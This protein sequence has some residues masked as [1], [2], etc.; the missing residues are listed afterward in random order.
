M[1][2][3]LVKLNLIRSQVETLADDIADAVATLEKKGGAVRG[4]A[5]QRSRRASGTSPE[6]RTLSLN[7]HF[8]RTG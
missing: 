2:R 3:A 5:C 6:A 4:R 8:T 1:L 7:I